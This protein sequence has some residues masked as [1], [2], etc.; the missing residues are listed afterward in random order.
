MF[1]YHRKFLIDY[2]NET[3]SKAILHIFCDH[4]TLMYQIEEERL[5]KQMHT[6]TMGLS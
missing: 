3:L 5:K 1:Y 2:D 4:D 6:R